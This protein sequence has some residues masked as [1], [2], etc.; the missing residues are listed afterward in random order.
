MIVFWRTGL[1]ARSS[2]G[3]VEPKQAISLRVVQR[4]G[5]AQSVAPFRRRRNAGNLELNPITA[6]EMVNAT[7]ECQKKFESVFVRNSAPVIYIL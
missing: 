5:V 6:F 7:V 2:V 1:K 3:I 4:K